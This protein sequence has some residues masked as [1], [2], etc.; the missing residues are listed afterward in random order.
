[1]KV[2]T[3]IIL[4]L[5]LL[6]ISCSTD[7]ESQNDNCETPTNL[8]V[9]S[10]NGQDQV[11]LTWDALEGVNLYKIEYGLAGF[12]QGD[13]TT[14]N[15]ITSQIFID[16]LEVNTAYDFYVSSLCEDGVSDSFG[17][18]NYTIEEDNTTAGVVTFMNAKI[19]G[20]QYDNMVPLLFGVTD[21]TRV[22]NFVTNDEPY[23]AIQGNSAPN[24]VTLANTKEINI[25]IP[26]S[27]W[28]T[29]TYL[30][31]NDSILNEIPQSHVNFVY[32]D[33]TIEHMQ[34]SE[35]G[36]GS[37]TI[38]EF[39]LEERFITGTFE[40]RFRLTAVSSGE[41]S[42]IMECQNGVFTYELDADFFD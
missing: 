16:N 9:T 22:V 39:N 3:S 37:I 38:T 34:A 25:F 18:L 2:K 35:E 27:Q 11:G 30:L 8:E 4:S 14:E 23:L 32:F 12:N 10:T 1:M 40:F 13:G 19:A 26:Q 28:A 20:T 29:G 33:N 42:D 31:Y 24:D 17:P 6:I 41:T 36:D 5:I 21:A 15:V 7:N